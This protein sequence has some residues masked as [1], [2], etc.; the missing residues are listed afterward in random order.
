MFHIIRTNSEHQDFQKLVHQ[1]DQY[2]AGVNGDANE[3]FVQHNKIDLINHVVIIYENEIAVGC[4]AIKSFDENSMEI[5]R[6]FVPTAHRRKGIA[7]K[8]LDELTSWSKE[9]GYKTCVL[10]TSKTMTDA[11][12]LYSNYGFTIIPNY[13]QYQEIESSVC[14]EK[15]I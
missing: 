12:L 11:V 6:M 13:S 10:E 9:L 2:L 5:K 8:I 4:G 7:R 1:L 14:F 3:F 15:S